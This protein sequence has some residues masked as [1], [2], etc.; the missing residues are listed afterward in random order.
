MAEKKEVKR[1]VKTPKDFAGLTVFFSY[2]VLF[3]TANPS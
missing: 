3:K 2:V 1:E